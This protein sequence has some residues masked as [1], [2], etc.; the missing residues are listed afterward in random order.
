MEKE[1]FRHLLAPNNSHG[2]LSTPKGIEGQRRSHAC[3]L[4]VSTCRFRPK[5]LRDDRM[6]K[7]DY[8]QQV[9]SFH[10]QEGVTIYPGEKTA[11]FIS[12]F[13]SISECCITQEYFC[14]S[15]YLNSSPR[16]SMSAPCQSPSSLH[17]T[18]SHCG[19]N[20]RDRVTEVNR[21]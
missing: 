17:L 10:V 20:K 15:A 16:S 21:N 1:N 19:P 4:R 9:S 7:G 14:S 13:A 18:P 12:F 2:L 11:A 8:Q 5:T 6:K 3:G